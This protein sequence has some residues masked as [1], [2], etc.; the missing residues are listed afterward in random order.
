MI[1]VRDIVYVMMLSL[2]RRYLERYIDGPFDVEVSRQ[3]DAVIAEQE[4]M[5]E[6][7]TLPQ[8]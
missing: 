2:R 5:A 6:E 3:L 1:P 8:R 7:R 4:Q